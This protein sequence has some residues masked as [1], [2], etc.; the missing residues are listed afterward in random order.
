M[1]G[2]TDELQSGTSMIHQE[3][4]EESLGFSSGGL[5]DIRSESIKSGSAVLISL[6]G[7]FG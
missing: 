2:S 5:L 4:V 1:K 6:R 7:E 3:L